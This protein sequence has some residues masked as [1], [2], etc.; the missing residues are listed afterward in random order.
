M[1]M[2]AKTVALELPDKGHQGGLLNEG[3]LKGYDLKCP[4][5]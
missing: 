1:E 5:Q 3:E 4:W 2:L